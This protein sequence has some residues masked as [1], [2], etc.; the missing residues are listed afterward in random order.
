[1]MKLFFHFLILGI[2][3][4]FKEDIDKEVVDQQEINVFDF[5]KIVLGIIL[6]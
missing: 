4:F 1:M 2:L 3:I 5:Y 6:N